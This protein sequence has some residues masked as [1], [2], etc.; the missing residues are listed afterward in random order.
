MEHY[1]KSSSVEVMG[2]KQ[3]GQRPSPDVLR[4]ME[5]WEIRSALR[6][7]SRVK[8][9]DLVVLVEPLVVMADSAWAAVVG[10][11]EAQ[12]YCLMRLVAA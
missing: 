7:G 8:E 4:L 12:V 6:C 2:F 9:L 11:L 3:L 1:K 5:S 10:L